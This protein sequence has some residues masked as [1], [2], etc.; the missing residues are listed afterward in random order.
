MV[1]GD[2]SRLAQLLDN[3]VANAVK[4]TPGGGRVDLCV[5]GAEG[6]A[7]IEVADTG[8]GIPADEQSRLFERFFRASS[9]TEQA[10][11]GTGLGLA[12]AKAIVQ[13]HGGEIAVESVEG[14]GTTFRVLLPFRLALDEGVSAAA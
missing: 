1:D 5:R 10:I 13:A 11:P 9:A 8:I 14:A 12:I 2:R 3:L 4:F 7:L 6:R